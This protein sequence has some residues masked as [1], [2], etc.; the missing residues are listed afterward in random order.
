MGNPGPP[1]YVAEMFVSFPAN[2]NFFERF[3]NSFVYLATGLFFHLY[4][5]PKQNELLQK[6]F[7]G[8][9]HLSDLYYNTSLMLINSHVS[10]NPAVPYLPN[11]IEIGGCHINPP[12]EL[13]KDLKEYLDNAKHGVIFFSMGSNLKSKDLPKEKLNDILK[14]FS[15]LKQNVLWKWE[16][17]TLPNQPANVKLSKWLPQQDVLAHSNVKLFITHGG[18]LSTIEAIYHG[19]PVVGIPVFADQ[20]RNMA[21]AELSGY[22]ISV[23]YKELNAKVFSSALNK[24]LNN[25]KHTENAKKRSAVMHDQPMKPL[26][27]AMFWIEYV[28]RH[29]GAPHLKTAALNLA[30]YQYLLLDVVVAVALIVLV[31]LFLIVKGV[32]KLCCKK[33]TKKTSQ[34]KKKN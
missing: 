26:D 11:M 21:N 15:K 27:R 31:P 22:G 13:P 18:L 17:E 16:D 23:P 32:K 8:A 19:V 25:P 9:P 5:F 29:R 10:I 2:M 30:W 28:L 34:A 33:N 14:V 12:K 24:I 4:T 3:Y 6:Y 1:S 7:P 20:E